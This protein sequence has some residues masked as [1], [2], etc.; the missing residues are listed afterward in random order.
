MLTLCTKRF[1]IYKVYPNMDIKIHYAGLFKKQSRLTNK[2][3]SSLKDQFSNKEE[4]RL[5]HQM[6]LSTLRGVSSH[7]PQGAKY[8]K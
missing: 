1:Q 2:T 8:R 5:C 3:C 7:H 4:N 6:F